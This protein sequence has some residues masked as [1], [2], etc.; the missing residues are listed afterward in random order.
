M[1]AFFC[2][3]LEWPTPSQYSRVWG[4]PQRKILH[5]MF[6]SAILSFCD[7]DNLKAQFLIGLFSHRHPD[8]NQLYWP[9]ENLSFWMGRKLKFLLN[10]HVLFLQSVS[11]VA[12]WK[13]YFFLISLY[14]CVYLCIKGIPL[15]K[16][17]SSAYEEI[18]HGLPVIPQG[19]LQCNIRVCMGTG[20]PSSVCVISYHK[21]LF[22]C[23][24]TYKQP[25][26][27]RP[28][29]LWTTKKI[30]PIISPPGISASL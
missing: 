24:P 22:L 23:P 27:Y 4:S 19:L 20:S 1:V 25:Q 8:N 15:L 14:L 9:T 17:Q 21:M 6:S 10:S 7:P 11:Y 5:C 30:H 16:L 13:T 2:L 29:Y 12:V 18:E 28:I 3:Y 26:S